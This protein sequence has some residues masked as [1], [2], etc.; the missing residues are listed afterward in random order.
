M[1]NQPHPTGDDPK[2]YALYFPDQKEDVASHTD[3]MMDH[4]LDALHDVWQELG[5]PYD[6]GASPDALEDVAVM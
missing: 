2:L 3:E 1:F 4:L 5:L 6:E